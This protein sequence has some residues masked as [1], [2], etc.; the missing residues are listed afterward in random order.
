MRVP[1]TQTLLSLLDS[2]VAASFR[3]FFLV[4]GL[5]SFDPKQPDPLY[6][7]IHSQ[8]GSDCDSVMLRFRNGRHKEFVN[9]IIIIGFDNMPYDLALVLHTM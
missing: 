4:E 9:N 5:Q 6:I 8:F 1:I 3:G 2:R 7:E